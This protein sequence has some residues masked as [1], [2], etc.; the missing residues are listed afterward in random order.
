MERRFGAAGTTDALASALEQ[1]ARPAP[2]G[3][4]TT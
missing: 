2:A 3:A 4:S 1:W